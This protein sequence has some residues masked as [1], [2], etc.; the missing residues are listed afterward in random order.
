MRLVTLLSCLAACRGDAVR[1]DASELPVDTDSADIA[2]PDDVEDPGTEPTQ[3]FT[4]TVQATFGLD[5]N[6]GRVVDYLSDDKKREA[7]FRIYFGQQNWDGRRTVGEY[8]TVSVP[9]VDTP[10]EVGDASFEYRANL[11]EAD[12]LPCEIWSELGSSFAER[13]GLTIDGR[14]GEVVGRVEVKGDGLDAWFQPAWVGGVRN[15]TST[16]YKM[17]G[18]FELE[19][20]DDGF[21]MVL[22]LEEAFDDEGSWAS[23]IYVQDMNTPVLVIPAAPELE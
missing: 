6:A 3:A 20:D 1:I 11:T 7:A 22:A 14:P 18:E 2:P 17:T 10:V 15:G 21:P 13:V 23:S 8:C 4:M 19:F 9:L 16:A 5:A 12:W